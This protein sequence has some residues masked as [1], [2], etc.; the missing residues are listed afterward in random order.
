MSG[1]MYTADGEGVRPD[2]G[3]RTVPC[4]LHK[5]VQ[6]AHCNDTT[7]APQ[8]HGGDKFEPGGER[9]DRHHLQN[10]GN[11]EQTW[12]SRHEIL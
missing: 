5:A 10:E 1:S 4:K 6:A 2:Y 12:R 8:P 7:G 9:R 11:R 3:T